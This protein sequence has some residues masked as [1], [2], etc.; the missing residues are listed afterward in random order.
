MGTKSALIPT[1]SLRKS[2]GLG[3]ICLRYIQMD[4]ILIS[5]KQGHR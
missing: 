3:S 2:E 4:I 1:K 5:Q